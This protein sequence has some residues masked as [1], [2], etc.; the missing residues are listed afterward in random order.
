MGY[1]SLNFLVLPIQLMWNLTSIIL[2]MD[3]DNNLSDAFC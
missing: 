1:E 3:K 2:Y